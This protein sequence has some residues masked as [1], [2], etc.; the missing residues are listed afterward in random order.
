MR[1]VGEAIFAKDAEGRL[2]SRIGTMFFRTPGLV[3]RKGVHV[4]QRLMWIE[5]LN[6]ERAAAGQPPLTTAEEDAEMAESVDLIFTE[7]LA[8]IR[9]NPSRMDLAFRADEELQKIVSKRSIRFLNT[10]SSAVRAALRARGENWR[11]ARQPI[12]QEDMIDLINSSKVPVEERPIYYYNRSTGTRFLTASSYHEV[13][14]L[15]PDA[16]RRQIAEIVRGL[17]KRNRSGHPEV[18]LFPVTTPLAIRKV[19]KELPV[20]ALDDAALKSAC[21]KLALDWRMTLPPLLREETVENFEW[22]NAMCHELTREPNATAAEEQEMI[23]GIA[24]EFYRQIE[25]LPGLRIDKG[26]VIFDPEIEV[27][28]DS[29]VKSILFNATRLLGDLEY[30]NIGRIAKSLARHPQAGNRRGSVYV[31][32]FREVGSTDDV[33]QMIRLQKWGV[34]ERLDE[35]K[36]FLQAIVETDEY[37]DYIL[38]R[39]LMCR[40]FGMALPKRVG[41]GHFTEKYRGANRYNGASIRTAYFSRAYV[42]GIASD[43]VPPIRFRNPSFAAR[44]AELMGAAAAIDMVVG[45]RSTVSGACVFDQYYEVLRLGEDGLPS[46]LLITDHAGSFV[47]YERNFEDYV[48]DYADVVCRRREFVTDYSGFVS[49]YVDGFQRRLTQVQVAYRAR[50]QAFERLFADRPYDEK[51]S[52]AYRWSCVLKRL[53]ACNPAAVAAALKAAI[54]C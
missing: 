45:R 37:S 29:R 10:S 7:D 23:A 33:V 44:F 54:A 48:G 25:W 38:D 34:A 49:A 31:L 13:E 51:G 4:M 14:R 28:G 47:E 36:D 40:Q 17:N 12:S 5:T 6:A 22:R 9:P 32:Q 26:E 21:D 20:D 50:R 1:I 3:T 19:F 8:L 52:G 18:D 43:K 46:E 39:R 53:D 2:L 42:P 24:P 41:Y 35:G 15:P 11:M 27:D 30:I 16:F